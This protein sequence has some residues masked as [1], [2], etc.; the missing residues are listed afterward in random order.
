MQLKVIPHYNSALKTFI[1]PYANQG[2]GN[3]S[4]NN[5]QIQLWQFLLELLTSKEYK[6][7]IQW[8]GK[9]DDK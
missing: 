2:A 4:G 6:S 3:K 9:L 7:V 1:S 8:T 5:G